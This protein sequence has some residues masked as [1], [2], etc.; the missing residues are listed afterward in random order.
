MAIVV[1]VIHV[2][3]VSHRYF[4]GSFDDDANYILTGRALLSGQGLAGH[5]TSGDSVVGGYPPGYPL[6][7]VPSL[8]LWPHTF[9]PLRLLSTVSFVAVFPLTWY[10]LGRRQFP[11]PVRIGVMALMALNPVLATYATMV[12]AEMP[13]LCCFLALLIAVERWDGPSRVLSPAGVAVILLGAGL[14]WL[15]EAGIGMTLGLVVWLAWRRQRAKATAVGVGLIAFL[16]PVAVAR[17]IDH[18]PLAGARY[19]EQLGSTYQRGLLQRLIHVV[20]GGI[21]TYLGTALPRSVVEF[22]SPLPVRG[23][24]YA[25]TRVLW[26]QVTVFTILGIIVACRRH[27]DAGLVVIGVYVAETLLYPYVNER[28]LVL[29]LPVVIA[30][31]SLGVWTAVRWGLEWCRRRR[32]SPRPSGMALLAAGT[33]LV[34]L[35]LLVQ[36]PRD[37]LFG[38]GQDT[39]RPQGSRYVAA[40]GALGS[41]ATVVES[42]YR[43][44]TALFSGHRAADSAFIDEINA[45]GCSPAVATAALAGDEAGF[46]LI[47]ALN[48]YRLIDNA[49]LLSLATTS[50]WAVRIMRTSRDEASVFELIGPGTAHP[51]LVD[52]VADATVAASGG[53]DHV[54]VRAAGAGDHPGAALATPSQ[55]GR[56]AFTWSFAGPRPV[57]QVSVGEA[58]LA[59]GAVRGVQVEIETPAGGWKTVASAPEAVGDGSGAAPF[60]LATLAPGTRARAVRVVVHGSGQAIALDVNALGARPHPSPSPPRP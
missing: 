2:V 44:A 31:Y 35:P 51:D 7:L 49:C 22:G 3:V 23:D 54:P 46:L 6:L 14:V 37:Y 53:L 28:R 21:D 52:L 40:L 48:K 36:F 59:T 4:V 11:D 43:Y 39:S 50:P 60:L 30:W 10:Y 57:S 18:V 47:G 38:L 19:S 8:W 25:A 58:G 20:P 17:L 15:K 9:V 1:A 55:D 56:A 42:D 29:A 34:A 26:V 27:R 5:L 32:W 41:A 13:F 24:W 12:M 16:V 45:G 33:L